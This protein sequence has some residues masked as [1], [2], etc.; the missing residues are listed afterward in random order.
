MPRV[1]SDQV[2]S[3]LS[4][5][6][7]P[8]GTDFTWYIATAEDFVTRVLTC[9]LD[10]NCKYPDSTLQLIELWLAA[11]F[12]ATDWGQLQEERI[13]D[14][15]ERKSPPVYGV[16]ALQGTTYG[17]TALMLDTGGY[18][19]AILNTQATVMTNLPAGR[20]VGIFY[21]GGRASRRSYL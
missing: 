20:K 17:K 13:G 18:I 1:T 9:P 11:H 15:I 14:A 6:I 2:L 21:L 8:E 10:A 7:V 12:W 16:Q 3:I 5:A 19:A 4:G